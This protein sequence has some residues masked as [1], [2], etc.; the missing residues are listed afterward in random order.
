M[1]K[2]FDGLE[3]AAEKVLLRDV[4]LMYAGYQNSKRMVSEC[5]EELVKRFDGIDEIDSFSYIL[6]QIRN[7][8]NL[9]DNELTEIPSETRVKMEDCLYQYLFDRL[10]ELKQLSYDIDSDF[11]S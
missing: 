3:Y 10:K 5:E 4:A 6:E 2:I 9:I 8:Y 7:A 1:A 11:D